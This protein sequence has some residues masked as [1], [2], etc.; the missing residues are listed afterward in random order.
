MATDTTFVFPTITQEQVILNINAV[1]AFI[2]NVSNAIHRANL[3]GVPAMTILGMLDFLKQEVHA[4]I[5]AGKTQ[6]ADGKR[7]N[8]NDN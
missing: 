5:Q 3:Q 7:M 8:Q 2:G 6:Y 1:N 4:G